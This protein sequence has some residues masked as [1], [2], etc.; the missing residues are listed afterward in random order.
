MFKASGATLNFLT[1][2]LLRSSK[3]SVASVRAISARLT[4]QGRPAAAG[5]AAAPA[6]GV[7]TRAATW[8]T[9]GADCACVEGP[10]KRARLSDPSAESQPRTWVPARSM[11]DI[12]TVFAGSDT[13]VPDTTRLGRLIQSSATPAARRPAR[14]SASFG[15]VR[16]SSVVLPSATR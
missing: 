16:S 9:A 6:T 14:D 2:G 7:A 5:A 8:G 15:I 3:S 13:V 11:R 1:G 12:A 4:D 10:A